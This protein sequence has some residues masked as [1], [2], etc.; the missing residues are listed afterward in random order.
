[1]KNQQ[2]K[3]ALDSSERGEY[4]EIANEIRGFPRYETP[5][6]SHLNGVFVFAAT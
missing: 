3:E 1:M 2:V 6:S 5:L 4:I